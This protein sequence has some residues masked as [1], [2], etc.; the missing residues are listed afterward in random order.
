MQR[1][2]AVEVSLE[3]SWHAKAS[4]TVC[5]LGGGPGRSFFED[6][7]I[8]AALAGRKRLVRPQHQTLAHI[9]VTWNPGRTVSVG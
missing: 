9:T 7:L 2:V 3:A 8:V 5:V 1:G 6:A 4:L